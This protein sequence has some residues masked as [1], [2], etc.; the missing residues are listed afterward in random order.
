MHMDGPAQEGTR[1]VRLRPRWLAVFGLASAALGALAALFLAV[2][3]PAGPAGAYISNISVAVVFRV[4]AVVGGI[5]AAI[6][7]F[8]DRSWALAVM[9]LPAAFL[10]GYLGGYFW[11]QTL[12]IWFPTR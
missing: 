5:G 12:G 1:T 4:V 8:T 6:A 3:G 9:L 11:A 10:I 7:V 2:V